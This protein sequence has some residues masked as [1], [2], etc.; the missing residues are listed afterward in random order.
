MNNFLQDWDPPG[1]VSCQWRVFMAQLETLRKAHGRNA[2]RFFPQ[3]QL[4]KS[5]RYVYC[6]SYIRARVGLG[7]EETVGLDEWGK[8]LRTEISGLKN[9]LGKTQS[10]TL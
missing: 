10:L 8:S 5:R 7:K 3:S 9:T 6:L 1:D 2:A 4:G